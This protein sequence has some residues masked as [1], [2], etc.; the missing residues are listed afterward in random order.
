MADEKKFFTDVRREFIS[1][2]V[3]DMTKLIFVASVV[4]GF[5]AS[6]PMLPR[7]ISAAVLLGAFVVSVIA[8]PRKERGEAS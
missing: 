7:L 1:R 2:S 3:M 4:G 8:F 5:F 6:A